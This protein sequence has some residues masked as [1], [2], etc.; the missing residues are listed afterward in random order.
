MESVGKHVKR[1]INES[2]ESNDDIMHQIEEYKES[3]DFGRESFDLLTNWLMSPEGKCD[4]LG[5]E[6]IR[7]ANRIAYRYFN[8][9]D[10]AGEGYGK[11]T[12]NPAV[13]YLYSEISKS[14][15]P[16]QA[17]RVARYFMDCVNQGYADN[18][19]EKCINQIPGAISQYVMEND[20]WETPNDEDMWD[21]ATD[22]DRDDSWDNE[23][24]W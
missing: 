15:V 18:S 8:D 13:R 21:Y 19:Y 12:V 2:M 16:S 1:A 9:G 24:D 4:T 23:E 17:K 11:E 7:A 14:G 20:L 10:M 5:G 22:M 6:I 3:G